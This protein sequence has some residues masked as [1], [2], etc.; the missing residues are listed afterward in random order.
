MVIKYISRLLTLNVKF[1]S[2]GP[3]DTELPSFCIKNNNNAAI[4]SAKFWMME[5][6][7]FKEETWKHHL[8]RSILP[9]NRKRC[10]LS[11]VPATSCKL[12]VPQTPPFSNNSFKSSSSLSL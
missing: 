11:T 8:H 1:L 10:D 2:V 12:I 6:F 7:N 9:I 4:I 5:H 3:K